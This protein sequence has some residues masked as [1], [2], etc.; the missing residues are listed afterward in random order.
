M[1]LLVETT[2]PLSRRL[3]QVHHFLPGT[4]TDVAADSTMDAHKL[5]SPSVNCSQVLNEVRNSCLKILAFGI[6]CPGRSAFPCHVTFHMCSNLLGFFGSATAITG[7]AIT[8][9]TGAAKRC[10]ATAQAGLIFAFSGL[11]TEDTALPSEAIA[12]LSIYYI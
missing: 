1:L 9:V 3:S 4:L 7:A 2:V 10:S 11:V 8:A 12:T 5:G 6:G